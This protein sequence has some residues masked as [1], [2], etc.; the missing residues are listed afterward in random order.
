MRQ[1]Y[2][3]FKSGG[4]GGGGGGSCPQ[5]PRTVY[6]VVFKKKMDYLKNIQHNMR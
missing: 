5:A 2:R 6:T 4:G 3:G 1:R